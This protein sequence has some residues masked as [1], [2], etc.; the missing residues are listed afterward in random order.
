[1]KKDFLAGRMDK[2]IWQIGTDNRIGRMWADT[3]R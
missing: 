1:M 2:R 3:E